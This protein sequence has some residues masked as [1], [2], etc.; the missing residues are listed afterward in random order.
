MYKTVSDTFGWRAH[1]KVGANAALHD[2][3]RDAELFFSLI[4]LDLLIAIL[5]LLLSIFYLFTEIEDYVTFGVAILVTFA[6]ASA[7]YHAILRESRRTLWFFYTFAFFEPGY[8]VYKL[9]YIATNS[10]TYQNVS[11]GQFLSTGIFA[12]VVRFGLMYSARICHK[13]FGKGLLEVWL[14]HTLAKPI[15]IVRDG[16][17]GDSQV[18]TEQP[19]G[20]KLTEPLLSDEENQPN[21]IQPLFSTS[22]A[23]ST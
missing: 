12:L 2:L 17:N 11:F 14:G 5:L 19:N 4:K 8:I 3:Y 20:N 7:G 15:V 16:A 1:R 21:Q 23:D 13:N 18:D 6:W 22:E 10:S 9:Y